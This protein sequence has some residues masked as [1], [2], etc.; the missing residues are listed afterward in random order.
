[1][2][3]YVNTWQAL[4]GTAPMKTLN[5]RWF[6]HPPP[7]LTAL[8]SWPEELHSLTFNTAPLYRIHRPGVF[9]GWTLKHLQPILKIQMANLRALTIDELGAMEDADINNL[10]LREFP[11]LERPSLP[12]SLTGYDV[13]YICR[14]MARNL[15]YFRWQIVH[16]NE[17]AYG[18]EILGN[19]QKNW[20]CKLWRLAAK[21]RLK[22]NT[23]LV[24][25]NCTDLDA[26]LTHSRAYPW[27]ALDDLDQASKKYGIRVCYN[28][29]FV[30]REE[31]EEARISRKRWLDEEPDSDEDPTERM[32]QY[33]RGWLW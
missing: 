4:E 29:P 13:R 6:R 21:R 28:E 15:Q 7:A 5:L 14:I 12:S 1:M 11:M 25:L 32:Y 16:R 9:Q 17:E 33:D 30:T 18:A 26:L 20:L 10:D 24:A 2:L 23:I 22:L 3:N 31:V 27:D 8:V 19:E